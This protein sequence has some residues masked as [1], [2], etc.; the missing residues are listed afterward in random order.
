MNLV[1]KILCRTAG[2]VGMGLALHDAGKVGA[3]YARNGGQYEQ[4]KYL[5]RRYYDSRTTDHVSYRDSRIGE[6][7]FDLTT[8]NP[9]PSVWGKTRGAIGGFLYGMGNS[10][11]MIVCSAM[12]LLCKNIGAKIG[13][14]GLALGICYKILR[15]GFGVGKQHPMN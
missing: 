12:A 15:E 9:L 2:A 3:L 5:E 1:G 13:V 6:K 10:L 4:S 11:P 8:K 7:V 14:A